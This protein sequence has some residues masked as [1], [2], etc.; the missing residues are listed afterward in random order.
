MN[1]RVI[2][3]TR[4]NYLQ[5]RVSLQNSMSELEILRAYFNYVNPEG[6]DLQIGDFFAIYMEVTTDHPGITM[7]IKE[8]F[9][10]I[11]T[12]WDKHFNVVFLTQ[13]YG[14]ERVLKGIY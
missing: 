7:D 12:C 4:D 5:Y 9:P 14:D 13:Q 11:L 8:I 1:N 6:Y 3:M 10:S 2:D